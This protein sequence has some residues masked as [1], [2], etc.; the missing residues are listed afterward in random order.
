MRWW[1]RHRGRRNNKNA[2]SHGDPGHYNY[3]IINTAPMRLLALF[4]SY[5]KTCD[6][7]SLE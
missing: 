2:L 1:T 4:G 5:R 6:K 3:L 7:V